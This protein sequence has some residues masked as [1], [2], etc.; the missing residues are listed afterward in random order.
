MQD[1]RDVGLEIE[2]NG[3]PFVSTR[4]NTTLFTHWGK[5]ML[6]GFELEASNFDHIFF[7]ISEDED[8][9]SET[10]LF[11]DHPSF[12][13]L[14]KICLKYSFPMVVNRVNVAECDIR[15]WENTQFSDLSNAEEILKGWS[16]HIE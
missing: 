1:P 4:Y 2:L 14:A 5:V 13:K 11:R 16:R 12:K 15:A 8:N 7:Q 6:K 10:Y 3:E 9:P